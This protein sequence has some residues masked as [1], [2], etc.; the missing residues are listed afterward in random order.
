MTENVVLRHKQNNQGIVKTLV[1][2]KV[3]YNLIVQ[4]RK[5]LEVK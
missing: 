3:R 2:K 4:V 5:K 1:Q